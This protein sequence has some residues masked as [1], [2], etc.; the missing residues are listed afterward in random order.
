VKASMLP[1]IL[2]NGRTRGSPGESTWFMK[3]LAERPSHATAQGVPS[4]WPKAVG[5]I[6]ETTSQHHGGKPSPGT[7][8]CHGRSSCRG[9][10]RPAP[11]GAE[12]G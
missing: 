7:G 2:H 12:A 11:P 6:L 9:L 1:A 3:G 4:S 8:G 5:L 10:D